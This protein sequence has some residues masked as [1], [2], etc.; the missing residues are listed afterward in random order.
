MTPWVY[1]Y[2][3]ISRAFIVC[4]IRFGAGAGQKRVAGKVQSM[5]LSFQTSRFWSPTCYQPSTTANPSLQEE[6]L[7]PVSSTHCPPK[8]NIHY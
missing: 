8:V 5:S 3:A 1:F 2:E 7:S 6:M 4:Y